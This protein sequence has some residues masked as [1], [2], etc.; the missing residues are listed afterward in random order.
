MGI[1]MELVAGDVRDILVLIGTDDRAGLRDPDRFGAYLALSGM[2]PTWLDYFAEAARI[3]LD[4]E[5]PTDFIDARIELGVED[6]ATTVERVDPGWVGAIARLPDGSLDAITGR[7]I[8]RLEEEIG[9]LPREEKPWIRDLA[10]QVVAFCRQA[11]R[12]PDVV[13]VWSLG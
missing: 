6:A 13:F 5:Q 9:E 1:R 3:T 12:Q 8:D 10:N 4:A 7:W 11:D 2:D